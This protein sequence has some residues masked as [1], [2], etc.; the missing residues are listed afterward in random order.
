MTIRWG[1]RSKILISQ[2]LS[3]LSIVF[4]EISHA[5]RGKINMKHI[6]RGS[7]SELPWV[8]LVGGVKRS[9]FFFSEYGHVTYRIKGNDACSNM[10]AC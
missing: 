3:Q 8:D 1:K 2:Q 10:V 5:D 9:R 4:T 6:K 7:G